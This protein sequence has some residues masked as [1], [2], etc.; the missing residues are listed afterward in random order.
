MT[1]LVSDY[2]L[3]VRSLNYDLRFYL[4]ETQPRADV[5]NKF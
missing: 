1:I 3:S 4:A 5:K 2:L